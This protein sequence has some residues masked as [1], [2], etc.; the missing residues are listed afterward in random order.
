MLPL[1]KFIASFYQTSIYVNEDDR[2]NNERK[3]INKNIQNNTQQVSEMFENSKFQQSPQINQKQTE[4]I[5][6]E[7]N[8]I[9]HLKQIEKAHNYNHG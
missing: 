6:K 1:I 3:Q 7:Y 8:S 9:F 4:E 2:Y 5:E